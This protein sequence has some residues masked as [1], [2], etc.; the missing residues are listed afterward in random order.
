MNTEERLIQVEKEFDMEMT[1][2]QLLSKMQEMIF[3]FSDREKAT[4][5]IVKEN[6]I[7]KKENLYYKKQYYS[8]NFCNL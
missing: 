1:D 5:K 4:E 7:L 8:A 2:V 6:D 3:K